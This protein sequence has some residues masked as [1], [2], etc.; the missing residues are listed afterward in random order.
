M[1][2]ILTVLVILALAGIAGA[3]YS[4]NYHSDKFGGITIPMT[5]VYVAGGLA[6][7]AALQ[8]GLGRV[9]KDPSLKARMGK[10]F[11]AHLGAAA[12]MY[13]VPGRTRFI[14]RTLNS[15]PGDPAGTNFCM[16]T[17]AVSLP[18]QTLWTTWRGERG[19]R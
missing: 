2:S 3:E 10:V 1:K 7:P 9:W 14:P 8:Y 6:A 4:Y 18:L 5:P 16:V 11:I 17:L 13:Y 19:K 12:L 15:D